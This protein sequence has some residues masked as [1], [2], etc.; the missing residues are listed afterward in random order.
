M[1]AKGF[2]CLEVLLAAVV[3]AMGSIAASQALLSLQQQD[4]R[5]LPQRLAQQLLDDAVAYVRTLPRQDPVSPVFGREPGESAV[6]DVD[7]LEREVEKGPTD[8]SGTV[9]SREWTRAWAVRSVDPSA[10]ATTAPAGSTPLLEVQIIIEHL[11]AELA[12]AIVL[13]T[14]TP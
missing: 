2:T 11:G 3:L 8:L 1:N 14:R 9:W 6:D 13:L 4:E 10:V 5:M 12:R 7:D